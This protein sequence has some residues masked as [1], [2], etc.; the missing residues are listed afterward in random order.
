MPIIHDPANRTITMGEEDYKGLTKRE[1]KNERDRCSRLA[2]TFTDHIYYLEADS[3]TEN[4]RLA[5]KKAMEFLSQM[6]L[7]DE[8]KPEPVTKLPN[9]QIPKAPRYVDIMKALKSA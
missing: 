4:E 7:K 5:V 2:E 8:W 1:L 6:I 3:W 9:T